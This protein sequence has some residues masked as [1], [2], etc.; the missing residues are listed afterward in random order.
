MLK[1]RNALRIAVVGLILLRKEK[2]IMLI[3]KIVWL[4]AEIAKVW[5]KETKLMK[6]SWTSL[7]KNLM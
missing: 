3:V 1:A 6:I 7:I 2:L 5:Q 4:I